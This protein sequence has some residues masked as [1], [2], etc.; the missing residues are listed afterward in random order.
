M[1]LNL[2]RGR[3]P[4]L[5]ISLETFA[6]GTLPELLERAEDAGFPGVELPAHGGGT[7]FHAP[8]ISTAERDSLADQMRAFRLVSA[9][10]PYQETFD[11]TLVSPSAAIRRASLSEIWSVC[12]FLGTVA[13]ETSGLPVVVLRSGVP[14]MGV[15]DSQGDTW[16]SESLYTLER[17][18]REQGVLLGLVS[19]DRFRRLGDLP[20]LLQA[21]FT[22]I[23]IALDIGHLRDMGEPLPDILRFIESY[24]EQI[25]YIRVPADPDLARQLGPVLHEVGYGG[26]VTLSP[27]RDDLAMLPAAYHIWRAILSLADSSPHEP[28]DD[29]A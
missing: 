2:L 10:A 1:G 18:A 23:G 3:A 19:R 27:D 20:P 5:S 6:P 24:P 11:V 8:T 14:P 4:V 9:A 29:P 28:H 22:Q 7:G 12:R 15:P 21:G 16:L 26:M 13:S 25:V 17:T